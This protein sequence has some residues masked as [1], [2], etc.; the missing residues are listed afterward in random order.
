MKSE[1]SFNVTWSLCLLLGIL[2]FPGI[3]RIYVGKVGTGIL[4]FLTAGG[5]F[6]WTTIDFLKIL[7]GKFKDKSG[8]VVAN[9][10]MPVSPQTATISGDATEVST[11]T[12]YELL[13][14]NNGDNLY[15]RH[16]IPQYGHVDCII[17]ENASH[18]VYPLILEHSA[19]TEG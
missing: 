16:V 5:L 10:T 7:E 2:G 11:E 13:R 6:F 15:T 3:H 12:P 14:N 19:S 9:D 8:M 18:D 17:G 4:M 1:K